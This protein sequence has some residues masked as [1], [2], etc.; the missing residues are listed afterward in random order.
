MEAM[1]N[2]HLVHVTGVIHGD[3]EMMDSEYDQT[4]QPDDDYDIDL[5]GAEAYSNAGDEEMKFDVGEDAVGYDNDDLMLDEGE[6][7]VT[8]AQVEMMTEQPA[9]ESFSSIQMTTGL[10]AESD[11]TQSIHSD[12]HVDL[13]PLPNQLPDTQSLS[14]IATQDL[15]SDSFIMSQNVP[16]V[17]V[18][19]PNSPAKRVPDEQHILNEALENTQ[20]EE[21]IETQE[22]VIHSS[23]DVQTEQISTQLPSNEVAQSKQA[24]QDGSSSADSTVPSDIIL[25]LEKIHPI[26]VQFETNTL[27][28]FNSENYINFAA[29]DTTE[30]TYPEIPSVFLL[31]DISFYSKGFDELFA[32]LREMFS[33]TIGDDAE[34]AMEVEDLELF[35]HEVIGYPASVVGVHADVSARIISCLNPSL[36]QI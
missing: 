28:L 6:F 5:D 33:A 30:S 13:P 9:N 10:T 31:Q 22:D 11:P 26:I 4:V 14:Q 19:V 27:A 7:Q 29:L 12:P 36:F 35:L 1:Q 15:H 8:T 3:D 2:S 24:V 23:H 34:I 16:D 20:Q 21:P 17:I 18:E 32:A 25:T